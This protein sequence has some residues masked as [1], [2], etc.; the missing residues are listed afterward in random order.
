[1]LVVLGLT[2]ACHTGDAYPDPA[3]ELRATSEGVPFSET[4]FLLLTDDNNACLID[5]YES[6]VVC[7][8]PEWR[9]V[10]RLGREG[11]GPGEF[12]AL[13]GVES[14][15]SGGLGV[16]D[17]GNRRATLLSP[18][19]RVER[20]IPFGGRPSLIRTPADSILLVPESDPGHWAPG[21]SSTRRR[22]RIARVRVETGAIQWDTL[23]V[24]ES[25]PMGDIPMVG[26]AWSPQHGYVFLQY[27]YQLI[28][29]SPAGDFLNVISPSHYEP[30]FPSDQDAKKHIS[31]LTQLFGQRPSD[32]SIRHWREKPK[33]G[34]VNVQQVTFSEDG[35]LWVAT[36]RD[37]TLW[38]YIDV[39]SSGGKGHVGSLRV[40]DRLLAFDVRQGTLAVLVERK[41]DGIPAYDIDWYRVGAWIDSVSMALVDEDDIRGSTKV[42]GR[43]HSP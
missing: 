10:T 37:R 22:T 8:G 35:L 14:L 40:R 9:E 31:D 38:S 34:V 7:G 5:S 16:V 26:G 6:Q 17:F 18:S 23:L 33:R 11:R 39:Y 2:A 3:L 25:V 13:L 42:T 12:Y 27:P 20:T 15:E 30:E 1:M 32:Q 21:Q 36:T 28:R 43:P 41:R 24:P 19:G 29:F 4:H